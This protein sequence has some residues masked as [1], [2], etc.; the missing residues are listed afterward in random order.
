MD[1]NS[2]MQLG[3]YGQSVWYDNIQR[4]LLQ[5][6]GLKEMMA[7][8]GVRGVTSNPTIFM[9]AIRDGSEYNQ[10]I[11]ALAAAGK[12]VEEI[13]E[14]LAIAD[15]R[16]AADQLRPVFEASR[17]ADGYVSM[18]VSPHLANQTV[19]TIAEARRLFKTIGRPNVMIKVPATPPGIPA[20]ET[21]IA[22]GIN[23]N[24]TLLFSVT[25]YCQVME[26][27]LRGLEKRPQTDLGQGSASV[28]SFF[29]SRVDTLVDQM[30]GAQM[31]TSGS[32][33]ERQRLGSLLGKA[34]I[35]NARVAYQ[36]YQ[37]TFAGLR[38]AALARR[39][40]RKQRI[41][42][43]STSTK[44][45]AYPDVMYVEG[46]IGPDSVDTIPPAALDAFRDHGVA[47]N[48]L[49]EPYPD[50]ET[51]ESLKAIGIDIEVVSAQLLDEGVELFVQ[52]FDELLVV[53]GKKSG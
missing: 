25:V 38:F 11:E 1:K 26:A 48:S 53:I 51:L 40:A 28:A 46:L 19:E 22:D 47:R 13:Y 15:I 29:V 43:A 52:A 30:L 16:T 31:Q 32:E 27:Y 49:A 35:A 42:W 18:E 8:D 39:G 4:Q 41:L 7:R 23:I 3:D 9:K 34:A 45:K 37:D 12:P 5:S 21:L 44:N 6:G 17:G 24:V 2:L 10:E 36:A 33:A 50:R 14:T 20:I